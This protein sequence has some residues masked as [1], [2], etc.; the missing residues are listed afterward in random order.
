MVE[1]RDNAMPLKTV[2]LLFKV[3][4]QFMSANRFAEKFVLTVR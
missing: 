2:F 4:K 3:P 1:K